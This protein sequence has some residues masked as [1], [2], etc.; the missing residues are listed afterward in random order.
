MAF[1]RPRH[2]RSDARVRDL[3]H[4]G[5][6]FDL[7]STTVPGGT[8]EDERGHRQG[9]IFHQF[10]GE[11][12]AILLARLGPSAIGPW[13]WSALSDA[14]TRVTSSTRDPRRVAREGAT[15][16]AGTTGTQGATGTGSTSSGSTSTGGSSETTGA[17]TTGGSGGSSST[18]S[19]GGSS[20]GSG[21]SS[22][23]GTG[24]GS[25]GA[26]GAGG[27]APND[28]G[29]GRSDAGRG[30]PD[31]GSAGNDGGRPTF[32][33]AGNGVRGKKFVGNITTR[34]QVRSDFI[35]YWDQITPENEGKWGSVERTHGTFKWAPLDRVHDYAKEHGIPFKQ[36]NFVWGSQQPT[37]LDCLSQAEQKAAVENWIKAFCERYPDTELIDVV[38]EPPPHTMPVYMAALGGA[39]TSGYDWIAQSFKWARQY[40]PKSILI[41]NDYN[42]IELAG[43]NNHT[44]DIVN[45]IKGVGAPIDGVG[46]QA[47]GIATMST[48]TVQ[49]FIDNITAKTS[50]PVYISEYDINIADDSKQKDVMQSQFTMM[51]NDKNV[52]GITVWGYV[53]GAT[54]RPNTGLMTSGGQLRPALT[55]LQ[56]F[57]ANP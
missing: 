39:G 6:Q 48:S 10:V 9:S 49:G 44:I 52:A 36:H 30:R 27:G 50:L 35:T 34:G 31:G 41:I 46:A 1:G 17:G 32:G 37:W 23:T 56:D 19:G 14:R 38:N 13:G 33:D 2:C 55:W 24:G 11:H 57:L 16:G 8:N 51:W 45:R 20:T 7:R 47:H 40:C 22:S 3:S 18:G 29:T 54:W 43:D 42:N 25:S 26:G 21:G 12:R 15:T 5:E 28:G 53:T 4:G